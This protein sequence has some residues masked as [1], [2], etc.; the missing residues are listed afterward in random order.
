M[1]MYK[2][3]RN[4]YNAIFFG[5]KLNPF[6]IHSLHSL[7]NEDG[8][9]TT[10]KLLFCYSILDNC[11]P[12]E[13]EILVRHETYGMF[14]FIN[15]YNVFID[16]KYYSLTLVK[17]YRV[18]D[19]LDSFFIKAPTIFV[20]EQYVEIKTEYE[21]RDYGDSREFIFIPPMS[22]D[23]RKS[24]CLFMDQ[25]M[26]RI[27]ADREYDNVPSYPPS[28]LSRYKFDIEKQ[29]ENIKLPVGNSISSDEE[30]EG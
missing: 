19:N 23:S 21:I 3:Y 9:I 18:F 30:T 20:E 2:I 4:I 6:D 5:T 22:K 14:Y 10:P 7:T 29:F 16:G 24:I 28:L 25:M 12:V 13:Y 1:N 8:Y 15:I 11:Y 17:P 27:M 26:G